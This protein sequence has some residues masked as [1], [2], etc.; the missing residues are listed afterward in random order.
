[1]IFFPEKQYHNLEG[2]L[3]AL[4]RREVDG[5]L[6]DTYVAESETSLF[7]DKSIRVIKKIERTFGYGIAL[8][9]DAVRLEDDIRDYVMVNERKIL[10]TIG[11][12]VETGTLK[13]S[14]HFYRAA[15]L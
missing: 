14:H 1:L 15:I 6:V 11:E 9:G 8:E 4:R 12:N 10:N 5:A 3:D 13:V 7:Q 2:V